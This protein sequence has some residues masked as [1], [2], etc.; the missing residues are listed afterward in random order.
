MNEEK[1]YNPLARTKIHVTRSN[2][3]LPKAQTLNPLTHL[4]NA[5]PLQPLLLHPEVNN[6]T[7]ARQNEQQRRLPRERTRRVPRLQ[8]AH[9]ACAKTRRRGRK[10]AAE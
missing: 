9:C 3:K 2:P 10:R 5:L 8:L 4:R 6:H 1:S 7:T